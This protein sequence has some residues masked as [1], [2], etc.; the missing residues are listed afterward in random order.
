LI[1]H[2]PLETDTVHEPVRVL[3][4][5]KVQAFRGLENLVLAFRHLDNAELTISGYGPLTERLSLLAA[6][7][8][9]GHKVHITGRYDPAEA[10]P[11]LSHHDIGVLPFDSVTLSI[12]YSSPNKL[13]DY[14]MGGLAIAASDLPFL[15]QF[16]TENDA[17][18][19]FEHNDPESIASTIAAMTSDATRLTEFKRNARKAALERYHWEKQFSG[20]YPWKPS[21]PEAP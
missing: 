6:S 16:I 15:K 13:F 14:A 18:M 2:G 3:Y 7:E 10:L 20:N 8:G 5:G 12:M 1:F 4:Q 17:G 9:I 19:V 21:R 11:I